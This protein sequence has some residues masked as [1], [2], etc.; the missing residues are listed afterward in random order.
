MKI[1]YLL[2]ILPFFRNTLVQNVVN[3]EINENAK[4]VVNF[5]SY[6]V[7][8]L[9]N[10]YRNN[11]LCEQD[12]DCP[13]IMKCCQIGIKKFCCSPNNYIKIVPFYFKKTIENNNL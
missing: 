10:I 13:H 3:Q 7:L 5:M 6:I 2:F 1:F 12:K 11:D 9:P 4:N 8:L